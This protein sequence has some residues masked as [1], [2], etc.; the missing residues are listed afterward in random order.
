[1][2]AHRLGWLVAL[3]VALIAGCGNGVLS[4]RDLLQLQ[5]AREKWAAHGGLDYTMESRISCFCPPYLNVWTRLTV[6]SGQ[7]TAAEPLETLPFGGEASPLGWHTVPELFDLAGRISG[8]F[9]KKVTFRFDEPWGYP[10]EISII[11]HPHIQD[12]GTRYEVR[13]L[14]LR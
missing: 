12:C 11:C 4:P 13:N 3:L 7:I 8:D 10:T 1:M 5:A 6:R 2:P 9:A 14:E